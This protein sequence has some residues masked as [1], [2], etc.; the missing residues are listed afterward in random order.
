MQRTGFEARD[1]ESL[2]EHYATTLRHWVSN[3]E[4]AWDRAVDLVGEARARIWRLYM[5][6]S[7]INFE[8]GSISIHQV[9]GIKPSAAG[10][11]GMPPTRRA[12]LATSDH[13]QYEH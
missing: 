10:D 13:E 8:S 12:M 3:L 5:A 2:R 1:V 6:G 11:S 9:L 7:A 4:Q